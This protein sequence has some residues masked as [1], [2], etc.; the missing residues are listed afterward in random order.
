MLDMLTVSSLLL[1]KPV[2][3]MKI[4]TLFNL[5]KD[6]DL[7]WQHL[8]SLLNLLLS[9]MNYEDWNIKRRKKSA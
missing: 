3:P 5:C 1:S 7:S 6:T 9:K 2:S 8:R 4:R